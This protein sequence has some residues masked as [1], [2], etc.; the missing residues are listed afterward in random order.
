MKRITQLDGVRGLAIL[1]VLVWH[2]F[3]CQITAGPESKIF[4][5]WSAAS[6]TWSGVDLFF[7]LSGFLI[8]GI[9]LDHHN[10]SNFFRIFYLRRACRIFPL[11][12]LLFGLFLCLAATPISKLPSFRWLF[13]DPLPLWSY[14]TFTQNFFM[15]RLGEFGANWLG[16]TWSLAVEEQFYLFVPLLIY[17]LPRRALVCILLPAILAAPLLRWASPGFHGFV[18]TPW[19]SDSL[20]AGALLAVLVRWHPF[21]STVR[22]HRGFLQAL[23]TVLLAGAAVLTLRPD[24]F[25]VFDHLWLAGLYATLIL[26]AFIGSEPFLGR[27]LASPVLVWFGQLSYGIYMFHQLVAGILHGA[28]RNSPPQI[29]T[30]SDAGIT[31]LALCITLVLATLSYRFFESPLL[32]FGRRFKYRPKPQ[33]ASKFEAAPNV[34]YPV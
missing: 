19:R 11:Y 14:A 5:F 25:G 22:R 16:V 32:R 9:L 2:Y 27:M 31:L 4:W 7:V 29:R 23:F 26:I 10:T 24:L 20:L 17:F 1:L 13:H 21:V 15:G 33:Q 30:L 8:A 18:N 3:V 6:L 28:I 34:A 12:F